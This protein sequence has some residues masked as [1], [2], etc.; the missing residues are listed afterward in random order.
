VG[1]EDK[2]EEVW[3][4][5]EVHSIVGLVGTRGIGKTVLSK[6]LYNCEK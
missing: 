1:I 5:M 6:Q 4:K 3:N 2:L